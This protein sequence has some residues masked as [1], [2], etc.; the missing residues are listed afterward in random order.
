MQ[1]DLASLF[2]WLVVVISREC[3]DVR[4]SNDAM[5]LAE[6]AEST[7]RLNLSSV[8]FGLREVNVWKL[9]QCLGR[10]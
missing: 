3:V 7:S 4:A 2:A 6:L 10:S 5:L 9:G 1:L 8:V